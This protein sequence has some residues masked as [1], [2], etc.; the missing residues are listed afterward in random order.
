MPG[1]GGRILGRLVPR[2]GEGGEGVGH[3][4]GPS[5]VVARPRPHLR[6]ARPRSRLRVAR[7]RLRVARHHLRVARPR[8]GA[9][10]PGGKGAQL[11]VRTQCW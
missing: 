7:P 2:V 6:V 3:L 8:L 4:Q 1:G 5:A 11:V 10:Q 9:A